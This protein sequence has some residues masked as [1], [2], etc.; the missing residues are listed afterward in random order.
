MKTEP[1][2]F[3]LNDLQQAKNQ[4][5]PWEGVRNYQARNFMRDQMQVGDRVLFYHSSCNIPGI[6]GL[7]R[8]SKAAEND[9]S[10]LDS[11]SPYFDSKSTTENVRWV[12]VWVKFEKKLNPMISLE[13]IK[14]H[15]KLQK[16]LVAKKGQRLSIQPVLKEHFEICSQLKI[17]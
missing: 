17:D 7:A 2:V 8:V 14:Q 10:A 1:A 6:V 5:S 4:E 12:Q 11:Q 15:P 9:L 16:M 13:L 3:S